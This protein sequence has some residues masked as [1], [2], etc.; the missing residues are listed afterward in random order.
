MKLTEKQKKWLLWG[1]IGVAA[2][3]ILRPQFKLMTSSPKSK[4]IEMSCGEGQKLVKSE[5]GDTYDCVAEN[6]ELPQSQPYVLEGAEINSMVSADGT[7]CPICG[8]VPCGC[9]RGFRRN[10][11]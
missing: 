4:K 11:F 7:V 6:G 1:G 9:G 10:T 3:L 8:N 5:M 2:Y